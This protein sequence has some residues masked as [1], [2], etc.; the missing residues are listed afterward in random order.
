MRALTINVYLTLSTFMLSAQIETDTLYYED[1]VQVSY[2]RVYQSDLLRHYFY[3]PEGELVWE[4]ADRVGTGEFIFLSFHP[5]GG[6]ARVKIEQTYEDG[7][8]ADHYAIQWD[9][10]ARK[11][12]EGYFT[13]GIPDTEIHTRYREDGSKQE[14]ISCNPPRGQ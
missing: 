8:A 13:K 6:L 11:T 1:G 4:Y 7:T 9:S 3:S 12:Y 5:E 10:L 14:V 2:I